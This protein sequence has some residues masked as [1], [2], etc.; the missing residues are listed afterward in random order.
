MHAQIWRSRD[1]IRMSMGMGMR[2]DAYGYGYTIMAFI[3]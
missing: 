3:S 2:N 1:G